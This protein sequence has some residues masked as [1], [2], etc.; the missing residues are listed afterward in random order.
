MDIFVCTKDDDYVI[1]DYFWSLDS[2]KCVELL[3]WIFV[4]M[5]DN[6]NE[7]HIIEWWR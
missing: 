6:E 5:A 7:V 4:V 1:Y 2:F 3:Q